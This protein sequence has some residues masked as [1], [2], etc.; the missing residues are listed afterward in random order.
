MVALT[1]HIS[2]ATPTTLVVRRVKYNS[3][4]TFP[5]IIF[6]IFGIYFP[7]YI[8][9]YIHIYIHIYIYIC[10]YIYVYIVEIYYI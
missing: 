4:Q 7:M 6:I 10:I 2:N 1:A 8:Y 9:T 3:S 5:V